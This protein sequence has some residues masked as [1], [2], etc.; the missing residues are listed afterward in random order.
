MEGTHPRMDEFMH[1]KP[2]APGPT[3]CPLLLCD[4][5][6]RGGQA[7]QCPGSPGHLSPAQAVPGALLGWERTSGHMDRHGHSCEHTDT[8]RGCAEPHTRL[9]LGLL[10]PKSP[11]CRTQGRGR[12]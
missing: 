8:H 7:R 3:T 12:D 6:D 2:R 1:K 10:S 11:G 4:S 5:R 9:C